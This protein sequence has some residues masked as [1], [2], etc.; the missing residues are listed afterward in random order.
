MQCML[1]MGCEVPAVAEVPAVPEVPA[2]EP[3]AT[4]A[5]REVLGVEAMMRPEGR[6]DCGLK[7]T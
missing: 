6:I 1:V 2:V 5:A 7:T 3:V 4:R